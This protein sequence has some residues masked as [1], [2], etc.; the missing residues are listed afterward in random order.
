MIQGWMQL[1]MSDF[2][3]FLYLKEEHWWGCRCYQPCSL[4]AFNEA[5]G[6]LGPLCSSAAA[7]LSPPWPGE[8]PTFNGWHLLDLTEKFF[9]SGWDVLLNLVCILWAGASAGSY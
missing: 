5:P 4:A 1:S 7:S 3:F 9:T 2:N 8:A 6:G